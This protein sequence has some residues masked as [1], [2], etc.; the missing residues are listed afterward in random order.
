MPVFGKSTIGDSCFIDPDALIGYPHNEELDK[1]RDDIE[2][3]TIGA[4]STIRPGAIYSTAKVGKNTRTGHN[5]L[6][7]ENT[8]VGDGCLI[9]TN[10]VIDNDCIVGDN[11]SFQTGAYIPTGSRIGDRVFLGP[12]ASLTNDK[13]PLRT[14]YKLERITVEND[15]TIGSNATLM[16]GITV[17]EGA[18]IAGGAVV[19]KDVPAWHIAKGCPAVFEELSE[20]LKKP[21]RLG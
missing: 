17:S 19:T 13:T 20:S 15:V 8:V 6:V 14:E 9:G 4:N 7:R 11:C 18:F 1:N 16:P 12:N 10:V 21:N 2:G 5:F 3:C